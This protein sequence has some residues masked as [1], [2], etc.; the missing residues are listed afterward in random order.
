MRQWVDTSHYVDT[1]HDTSHY[2]TRALDG[3]RIPT[4]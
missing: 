2:E 1:Y 4:G 3:I